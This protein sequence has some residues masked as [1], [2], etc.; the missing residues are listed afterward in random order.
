M[1]QQKSYIGV[2]FGGKIHNRPGWCRKASQRYEE[3]KGSRNSLK[4]LELRTTKAADSTIVDGEF[5]LPV[6]ISGLHDQDQY[7]KDSK[8][9]DLSLVCTGQF[10]K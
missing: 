8:Q 1:A 9:A 7:S 5:F 2:N 6:L 4:I 3:W 10:L